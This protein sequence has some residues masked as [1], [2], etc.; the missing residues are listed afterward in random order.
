MISHPL[1]VVGAS[2]P[3]QPAPIRS[4]FLA[5]TDAC[6]LR[7]SYCFVKKTPRTMSLA[8]L[9]KAM[10]FFTASGISRGH[11]E[12]H[13][14]FFGGEPFLEPD[15]MEEALRW[16][17]SAAAPILWNATTNGTLATPRIEKLVR[18]GEMNLLI[19]LDGDAQGNHERPFE[20]GR[21]SY[22]S[23]AR[24]LSKLVSWSR[25][26]VVRMTFYPGNLRLVDNVRHALELGA[27][28]V[29]L[30]AVVESNWDGFEADLEGAYQELGEWF[31]SEAR[32]GRVLPLEST[33]V[34]LRQL[35]HYL[36]TGRKY[37]KPCGVGTELLGIDPDGNVMPCHRF[38]YRP[39]DWLGHVENWQISR[40]R[41]RYL[42]LKTADFIECRDCMAS[43]VCG[44]GCRAVALGSGLGLT[45]PH[46]HHCLLTRAHARV[47]YRIYDTLV[48]EGNRLFIDCL[49]HRPRAYPALDEL[50]QQ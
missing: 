19:S 38:L 40:Q 46:P 27:P 10:Q 18:D 43:P 21:S 22:A 9:R 31:I 25:R 34:L 5:L 24:N 42:E 15:L 50:S 35:H 32:K 26:S 47:A 14:A 6:N 28:S 29:V 8:T 20:S 45:Q 3:V 16:A 39:Q 30:A 41:Q 37:L 7:C 23:V 17:R 11:D 1:S 49:L 36:L 2:A 44:G 48:G 4:L 33:W 13:V 12:L